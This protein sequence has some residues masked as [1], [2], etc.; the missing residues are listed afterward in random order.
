MEEKPKIIQTDVGM[1]G[2]SSAMAHLAANAGQDC[3]FFSNELPTVP[4]ELRYDNPDVV[5]DP[6][7]QYRQR[8]ARKLEGINIHEEQKLIRDKKSKLSAAMRRLVME[9][10]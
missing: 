3:L 5:A 4:L 6:Y 1:V 8:I 9:Q 2:I 10:K 7:A